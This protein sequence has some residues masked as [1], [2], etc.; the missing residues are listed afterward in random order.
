MRKIYKADVEQMTK[1]AQDLEE[2][3]ESN[4]IDQAT[5]FAFN[6]CID[7][8]FTNS[9]S[10]AYADDCGKDN[11]IEVEINKDGDYVRAFVRDCGKMFNPLTEVKNPDLEAKLEDREIGGLGI[12]FLKKNMD[13]LAYKRIGNVN[14]LMFAKKIPENA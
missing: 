4:S 12:F 5:A 2:F 1:V 8:I 10:Y 6:L 7:E 13:E 9:A 3:F 14:E 11:T